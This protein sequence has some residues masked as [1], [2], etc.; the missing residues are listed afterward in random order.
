MLPT[1]SRDVTHVAAMDTKVKASAHFTALFWQCQL[2][3]SQVGHS[4][5]VSNWRGGHCF[6]LWFH[7]I[8]I[9]S[10]HSHRPLFCFN[11]VNMSLSLHLNSVINDVIETHCS[12]DLLFAVFI[13]LLEAL[14]I[15]ILSVSPSHV[16]W[17]LLLLQVLH[18]L[19]TQGIPLI[20]STQGRS[21]ETTSRF[22]RN[23]K[24]VSKLYNVMHVQCLYTLHTT[25]TT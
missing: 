21:Y 18:H 7:D 23:L 19:S 14:L 12:T 13:C 9:L 5:C 4:A 22:L 8:T 16:H 17:L 24:K 2:H 15:I 25:A 6:C 1:L 20:S 10:H 11:S 3:I